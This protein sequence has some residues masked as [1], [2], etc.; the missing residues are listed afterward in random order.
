MP[1]ETSWPLSSSENVYKTKSAL[2]PPVGLA[3]AADE[4]S[5]TS[6]DNNASGGVPDDG[7]AGL[8]WES[9]KG[10]GNGS[11]WEV[12]VASALSRIITTR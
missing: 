12:D 6:R 1:L 2:R 7:A 8:V 3:A 5:P 11:E 9:M 10:G 4:L